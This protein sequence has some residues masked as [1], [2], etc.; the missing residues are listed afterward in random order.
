VAETAR[1]GAPGLVRLNPFAQL[2]RD[3]RGE[4][5][6]SS[7]A[8][9]LHCSRSTIANIEAGR[10]RASRA[11]VD[12]FVALFPDLEL[13]IFLRWLQSLPSGSKSGRTTGPRT[14]ADLQMAA[15]DKKIGAGDLA[16]ARAD[17]RVFLAGSEPSEHDILM[18]WEYQA[19]L[20]RE[21]WVRERLAKV[22]SLLGEAD[23]AIR[24][25]QDAIE[26]E[27]SD[28]WALAEFRQPWKDQP[29]RLRTDLVELLLR[30][31]DNMQ[32]L[33]LADQV[34]ENGLRI[35]GYHKPLLI[36]KGQI[37]LAREDYSA[38]H[39]FLALAQT[40]DGEE[41]ENTD[42]LLAQVLA[43]WGNR[44]AALILL[45]RSETIESPGDVAQ[46]Y[47]I[48]GYA[49]ACSR[50]ENSARTSFE[51]ALSI[52]TDNPLLYYYRGMSYAYRC[53]DTRAI[54]DLCRALEVRGRPLGV[55]KRAKAQTIL[56]ANERGEAL[57]CH[58]YY[59]YRSDPEGQALLRE[60][61]GIHNE[62]E[63]FEKHVD[64]I[65]KGQLEN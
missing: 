56:V 42:L 10:D 61:A 62:S 63:Y 54:R 40:V 65:E 28:Y 29:S 12:S 33:S 51:E 11:L 6:Q 19:R 24:H 53:D 50:S 45:G 16:G 14:I 37:S 4:K 59:R 15:I 34:V 57:P 58:R 23:D 46:A 31:D 47:A 44:E 21:V 5:T 9:Q 27:E 30:L 20:S 17:L 25:Y 32:R 55:A 8:A 43:E 18:P 22:A 7:F 36:R 2:V 49:H 3:L 1:Y 38:A 26:F 13:I 52:T 64:K 39:A 35:N 48:A 41:V 60:W